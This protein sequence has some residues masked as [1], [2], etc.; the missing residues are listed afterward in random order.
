[1]C[2]WKTCLQGPCSP[3]NSSYPS[4]PTGHSAGCLGT[5]KCKMEI[6]SGK[7]C[8]RIRSYWT[9]EKRFDQHLLWVRCVTNLVLLKSASRVY[10]D[11]SLTSANRYF[12]DNNESNNYTCDE[13]GDLLWQTQLPTLQSSSEVWCASKQSLNRVNIWVTLSRWTQTQFQSDSV[14]VGCVTYLSHRLIR[15]VN[16]TCCVYSLFWHHKWQVNQL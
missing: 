12:H 13:M 4:I 9:K 3:N 11:V 8:I 14:C 2:L 16:T 10:T 15:W 6:G 1:M 7:G 5:W